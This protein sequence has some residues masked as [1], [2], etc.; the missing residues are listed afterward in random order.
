MASKDQPK[1]PPPPTL[2]CLAAA[3]LIETI[4]GPVEIVK[5]AGKSTPVLTRLCDGRLGFRMM[6]QVR[7]IA[8]ETPLLRLFNAD[9]QEVVVGASHVFLAPGGKEVAARDLSEGALLESS[10]TYP[11]GYEIPDA[12]EYSLEV[13]GRPWQPALR[14]IR[15]EPVGAGPAF[16]ASVSDTKTYF[17]TFGAHCRAQR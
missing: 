11:A 5:L 16:G 4:D 8:S 14:V 7:E 10:W 9:R 6:S 12:E 17:L 3:S 1:P 15:I 2:T 13:R